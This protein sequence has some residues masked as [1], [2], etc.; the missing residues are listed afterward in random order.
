MWLQVIQC[1][2]DGLR[3]KRTEWPEPV[4]GRLVIGESG[5]GTSSFRRA[6]RIAQ[7]LAPAGAY[8]SIEVDVVPPLFEP[9]LLPAPIGQLL[10]RGTQLQALSRDGQSKVWEYE[11]LWLCSWGKPRPKEKPP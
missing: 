2:R 3:L 4:L 5:S 7:L 8:Q 11:Q 10:L 9:Q 6:M 1:R